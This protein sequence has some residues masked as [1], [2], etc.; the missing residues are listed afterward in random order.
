MTDWFDTF[1]SAFWI[2][3]GTMTFGFLAVALKTALAS[4]CDDLNLCYGCVKIHRRVEL[5]T[6]VVD[7][8]ISS[9]SQPQETKTA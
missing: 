4:K 6:P 5:E 8:P 1:N 9:Q 2:T 7:S 3:V